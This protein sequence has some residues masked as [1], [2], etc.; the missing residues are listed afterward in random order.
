M[1]SEDLARRLVALFE[2]ASPGD[3][4]TVDA[5]TELYD[6]A[7]QFTDPVQ[8]ANGRDAFLEAN[9]RLVQ[10]TRVLSFEIHEQAVADENIFLT[11]TMHL[12]MKLGPELVE[13]GV[14]HLRVSNGKVIEHRDFW[15]ITAFLASAVPGG[16]RLLR[17]AFKPFV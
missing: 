17:A 1:K 16:R 3:T 15:D 6:P 2:A 14:T 9:R 10:R 4:G 7:V 11:W 8:Q 13:Q 12:A 5:L